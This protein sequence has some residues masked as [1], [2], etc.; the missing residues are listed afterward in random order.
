M[1]VSTTV[2]GMPA[3]ART[4]LNES[5][6]IALVHHADARSVRTWSGTV[7]FMKRALERHVGRVIDLSPY[8]NPLLPWKVMGKGLG[9]LTGRRSSFAHDPALARRFG[10]YFSRILR[11]DAYDLVFAPAASSVIAWLETSLPV[12]YYSDATWD[13]LVDYNASFTNLAKRY[14]DGGEEIERRAIARADLSLFSSEWGARSAVETY[15]ALPERV[16]VVPLGANLLDP[17]ARDTVLPRSLGPLLQLLFCGVS[18][19]NKGGAIA[20]RALTRLLKMGIDAE[21]TIL[22]CIPPPS[23]NHPQMKVVPFLDKSI[24]AQRTAFEQIWRQA[25]MF[26]LPTRFEA[27]GLVF[28]EAGAYGIP[29]F[30]PDTGGISSIVRNGR[31]GFLLPYEADGE[32][33]AEAIARLVADPGAYTQICRTSR[34]EY[35]ERLNWDAWGRAVA[36][37]LR[38]VAAPR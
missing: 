28:C 27:A 36:P 20:R 30:A 14:R 12:V 24:P 3:P 8:P 22:G 25:D 4:V 2:E 34:D 1:A 29:S 35:E 21:M 26:I 5:L 37:L 11:N 33:Y 7:F 38:G 9:I 19:R 15:G 23:E 16:G 6:R 10:A 17:P 32:A 13:L 18:Y 31:N